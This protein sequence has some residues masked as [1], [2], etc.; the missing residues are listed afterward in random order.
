MILICDHRGEGLEE[1]LSPPLAEVD[2]DWEVSRSMRRTREALSERTPDVIVLDPLSS[3]GQVELE[4]IGRL[5]GD[6]EAVPILLVIDGA[7]PIPG[8]EAARSQDDTTWDIVHRGAATE[9]FLVRIERLLNQGDALEE[10]DDLRYR[11]SHDDRTELLRPR[12]FQARLAEHFSAAGRHDLDLALVIVD[13]DRFGSINKDF[14]HTVGDLVI[15]RVG[16]VIK[17]SL[18]AEDI[19]ARLGGDEFAVLLPYTDQ[20]DTARVVAR[21]CASIAGL[22]GHIGRGEREVVVSASIGFETYDGSDLDS[23]E[24]LRQHAEIALRHAKRAG[25]NAGMYYRCL[26]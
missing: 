5:R 3:G 15:S 19:G 26:L 16:D 22:S 12:V 14:D 6:E 2:L 13:L 8:L 17:H 21:L 7:N 18:R 11:A 25:G 9:E 23:V 24:T 10:V 20:V 1:A 4:E